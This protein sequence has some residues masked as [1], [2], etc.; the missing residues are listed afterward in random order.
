MMILPYIL[1][2]YL[3][4]IKYF[5]PLPLI[6]LLALPRLKLVLPA[7][8]KKRPE[9]R[10]QNFPE[11]QGGWPLYFAPL[12]FGYNRSFGMLFIIGVTADVIT[13]ILFTL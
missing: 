13:R 9:T 6:V 10:P 5:T 12:A 8:M 11:G 1:I 2:A 7:F 4:A 3:V